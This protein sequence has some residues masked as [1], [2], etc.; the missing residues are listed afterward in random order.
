MAKKTGIKLKKIADLSETESTPAA[1]CCC[2]YSAKFADCTNNPIIM[3]LTCT[4]HAC[5]G[6]FHMAL[7]C[8]RTQEAPAD[9]GGSNAPAS[10]KS[11]KEAFRK[12]ILLSF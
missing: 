12:L 8:L 10:T 9:A 5:V 2:S 11:T 1:L 7:P 3:S 4:L 6:M